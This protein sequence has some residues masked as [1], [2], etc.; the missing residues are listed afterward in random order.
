VISDIDGNTQ[1]KVVREYDTQVS[2]FNEE[3][4]N[5]RKLE[6]ILQ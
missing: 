2:I 3:E 4:L 5:K 1:T 6:E